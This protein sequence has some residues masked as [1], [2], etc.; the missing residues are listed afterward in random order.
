MSDRSSRA[1]AGAAITDLT[2]EPARLEEAFLE[3]YED[4]GEPREPSASAVPGVGVNG[5]LFVH[6]WRAYRVRLLI[7]TIGLVLWGSILPIVFDSFGAQFQQMLDSG[8]I[9]P[10]VRPVRR[11]RHLQPDRVGRARIRP[12]DLGGSQ[13]RLRRRL[14]RGGGGRRAAARHAGDPPVAAALAPDDVRDARPGRGAVHRA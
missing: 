7:V 11:R 10:A 1:I 6:T 13:P 2:I 8:L 4:A 9:P 14:L 12:P 5:A 3:F